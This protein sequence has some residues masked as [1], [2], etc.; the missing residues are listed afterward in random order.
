M[1]L[2]RV[3]VFF[4][5]Q[6]FVWPAALAA[7][8]S[9]VQLIRVDAQ[10]GEN[11]TFTK[12]VRVETTANTAATAQAM[13]KLPLL[14]TDKQKLEILEAY[15]RK[16]DGTVVQADPADFI[17][18]SGIVGTATSFADLKIE[19]VLFRDVSAGDTTVIAWRVIEQGHYFP[20]LVSEFLPIQPGSVEQE[21]EYRLDAPENL[22]IKHAEHEISY[23]ESKSGD[24]VHRMWSG[25]FFIP[26]TDEQ[27]VV[28]ATGHLP[29]L[30]FST[31]GSYEQIGE[32]YQKGVAEKLQVTPKVQA[33]ADEITKDIVDQRAQAA[34]LFDWITNNIRPV[35]ITFGL[36]RFVPNDLDTILSRRFGDCKDH[37]LLMSALLKAKGIGSEQVLINV[38]RSEN[39]PAAPVLQAFNHVI[40]YVPSF[41]AYADPTSPTSEFGVPPSHDLDSPIV[42]VSERG[43]KLT[44][45]P[46]G[47][48]D[49]NLLSLSTHIVLSADGTRRGE[50]KIS[51][52]GGFAIK[53]RD[54]VASGE[55]RGKEIALS[56]LAKQQGFAGDL[57][58]NAPLSTN[59]SEPYEMTASWKI[60]HAPS[61][62]DFGWRAPAALSPLWAN[63]V[64]FFGPVGLSKR[65]YPI[66]CMPGKIHQTVAAE[67][68]NGVKPK[69]LPPAVKI[70]KGP[71]SFAKS[72]S[73]KD[74]VVSIETEMDSATTSRICSPDYIYTVVSA[75]QD[76]SA[77]LDP[78]LKFIY[79]TTQK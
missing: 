2:V 71:F 23:S 4:L 31:Y 16:A 77:E 46:A 40:V 55:A 74:G 68:P 9:G 12:T 53:I 44:R 24:R 33:L 65:R 36:G 45:T 37:A 17:I 19:Q 27:S 8:P 29:S 10:V 69:E 63:P 34:A 3:A 58:M 18:Q 38:Q 48:A 15:T 42:R 73:F 14:W 78:S 47:S 7:D 13:S 57:S 72:W 49:Q 79:D 61:I 32:A 70:S 1:W 59:H 64:S 56:A 35:A 28:D 41:D 20:D 30:A 67:L 60:N 66:G 51:G 22:A 26:K 5:C 62:L 11:M 21:L 25:R 43:S 39:L 54:F 6:P 75:L 52:T 50:S 76:V